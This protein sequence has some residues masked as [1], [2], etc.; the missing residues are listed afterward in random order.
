MNK[1]DL[2]EFFEQT[3]LCAATVIVVLHLHSVF[4]KQENHTHKYVKSQTEQIDSVAQDSII[5]AFNTA[6]QWGVQKTEKI[7]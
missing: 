4:S 2:K 5:T 7:R 3:L 1:A 6:K